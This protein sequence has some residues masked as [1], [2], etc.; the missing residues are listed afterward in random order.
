MIATIL[1]GSENF[2]A[3]GYNERKVSKGTAH[4]LEMRNFGAVGVIQT[5]TPDEKVRFLQRYSSRNDRV[6]KA[7]FHVAISC[8][9]QEMTEAQLLDFTHQYLQEMGYA[10][11]GQPWLIYAHHDTDNLHL[12]IVTSRVAPDGHKINHHH[13]RRHSQVVVDK[14]MG[15]NRGKTTQKDIEAA[16]HYH[17]SSFAQFKAILVSMGYEVY[18]KEEMV[19]IK[20]GGRIQEEIPLP[21][22]ELFYQQPQSD[23]VR[24]RQLR[25]ILKS[26]RDVSANQEDLKQTLKAKL[27]IDL[28]FFGRKDAPYGFMLVD[29]AHKRVIHGARILSTEELLDFATP[30]QRFERIERFI[31][32][33][34]TIDPKMTQDEIFR[35]L[36]KQRAYIKRGVIYYDGKSRKL[37]PFMAAAIDRNNRIHYIEQFHPTTETER[38]YLCK[39]YKVD[40]KDLVS[41]SSERPESHAAAVKRLREIFNDESVHFVRAELHEDGFK[42][43]HD[44]DTYY[45]IDFHHH[46]LINLNTE[47]FELERVKRQP[48]KQQPSKLQLKAKSSVRITPVPKITKPQRLSAALKNTDVGSQSAN[49]EWEVGQ[50]KNEED[51]ER[52]RGMKW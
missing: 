47:G 4:L 49:R 20:K 1:P 10:E 30:D 6:R 3:V 38:D 19:F 35:K 31:D 25:E 36:R 26:Y 28:V 29:H 22:L 7:Q 42:V 23:R 45:A 37:P 9:G 5:A 51:V 2:H 8:K 44:G 40:R 50:K 14:L 18:K 24:N 13:E 27:G 41:L 33:L 32:N 11:P 46:I 43:L 21:V 12:H 48:R 16:K 34:L 15:I 17:F 39:I 52:G